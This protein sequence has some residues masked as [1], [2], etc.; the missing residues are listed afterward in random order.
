MCFGRRVCAAMFV[1][2]AFIVC[3][4]CGSSRAAFAG[5]DD[6][7]PTVILFSGRDIWRN[8]VFVYG[9]FLTA[10]GGFEQDGLMLKV[11]LSG[12]LYR[13]TAQGF[14]D[15]VIGAEW[16]AQVLPGW[17]IKR[18]NVEGKFFF[19]LDIEHHKLWPDDPGNRM[20]GSDIGA[21]FA[22]ELW[23]EPTPTTMITGDVSLSTI[24]TNSSARLAYGWRV[25]EDIAGGFYIGPEVQY[26][27]SDSYR[28]LRLG[29]HITGMKTGGNEWSAAGGWAGDSQGRVSPYLR[30]G[31]M[32]RQ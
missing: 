27:G 29:T 3:C 32:A 19:G 18:G 5:D 20:R 13:Y 4:V 7:D 23:I 25:L 28:H 6:D 31:F 30:L 12:G 2:A 1:A 22:V 24:A 11:L 9:G 26:F 17:R 14:T 21:R 16:L 8:G 15:D 10:P